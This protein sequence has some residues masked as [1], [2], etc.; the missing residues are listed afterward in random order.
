MAANRRNFL[1]YAATF[2][3]LM[4]TS[5]L[6]PFSNLI[7]K[8]FPTP[9]D[10][11]ENIR[12]LYPIAQAELTNLNSGSAGT[13]PLPVREAVQLYYQ[14][15]NELPLYYAWGKWQDL[16]N[17]IKDKIA[18]SNLCDTNEIAF[19]RNTTEAMNTII[20]GL[21]L[22]EGDEVIVARHDYPNLLGTIKQVCERR[23]ATLKT[24]KFD[25]PIEDDNLFL[26]K[27]QAAFTP[28][29]K[30]LLLTH[31]THRQGQILPIKKLTKL[32]HDNG[33]EV[34]IDAAHAFAHIEHQIGD[35]DCDYYGTSLH[36]WL[37]APFGTGLLF[38]KK[39]KIS[40]I[41]PLNVA[42]PPDS[43]NIE[44]LEA[45]GTRAYHLDMGIGAALEFFERI[46]IKRKQKQLQFLKNYWTNEAIKLDRVRLH[47]SL[48]EDFSCGIATFSIDG[49]KA[50]M[51]KKY[52]KKN[53]HLNVKSVGLPNASAIRI[54]P[55]VYNNTK[56]LDRLLEGLGELVKK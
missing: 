40:K 16:R 47:T 30:L 8:S 44:K 48:K 25:L 45:T 9:D 50:G 56:E 22:Q 41:A 10:F 7:D 46:G 37:C 17:Q 13:Q 39:D 4:A 3:T 5:H 38:V 23:K 21:P 12:K 1:K 52:L 55:N 34:M 27:Y 26:E 36:K 19:V 32:A 53:Q 35:L 14:L 20:Y 28:K 24:L 11:W 43:D 2:S 33:I 29:T 18:N 54:T 42:L 15:S 49:L 6:F 31:V 51:I